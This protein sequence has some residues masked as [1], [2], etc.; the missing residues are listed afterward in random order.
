[1]KGGGKG[2]GGGKKGGGKFR[3]VDWPSD[4]SSWGADYSY[5]PPP[6]NDETAT[7]YFHPPASSSLS[8]SASTA[9]YTRD[10]CVQEL[11]S[12]A[13]S[14]L[15]PSVSSSSSWNQSQPQ[16]QMWPL[17]FEQNHEFDLMSFSHGETTLILVDTGAS[18]SASPGSV[19]QG[20]ERISSFFGRSFGTAGVSSIPAEK[21]LTTVLHASNHEGGVNPL[22]ITFQICGVSRPI[23]SVREINV[24]GHSATIELQYPRIVLKDGSI[25]PLVRKCRSF[26]LPVFQGGGKQTF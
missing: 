16:F 13:Q 22:S 4:E 3:A 8:S 17:Y 26:F 5:P 24:S 11:N 7:T 18:I 2:G 9:A 14:Q 25:L 12:H 1:M 19:F 15:S 10:D 20:R 21:E 6:N 23:L